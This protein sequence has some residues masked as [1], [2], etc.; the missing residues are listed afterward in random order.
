MQSVCVQCSNAHG[1]TAALDVLHGG[2][3][4]SGFGL[5]GSVDNK[6]GDP[7]SHPDSK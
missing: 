7:R 4:V 5:D 3:A 1:A 2:D 6:V